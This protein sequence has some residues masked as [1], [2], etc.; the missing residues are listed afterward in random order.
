[1]KN[2]NFD[3]NLGKLP[4]QCLDLE[5]AVLGAIMIEKHFVKKILN[6]LPIE[7]FYVDRHQKI[8][9]AIG[10]LETQGSPVDIL[11]VTDKLRASGS[12]DLCGGPYY[13]TQL[14]SRVASAANSEMHA[15]IILQ[16]YI[17][18][19]IILHGTKAIADAYTDTEDVFDIKDGIAK[20]LQ[21]IDQL[22]SSKKKIDY[23]EAVN[24][25]IAN[26]EAL[27]DAEELVVGVETG[28]K[29][30]DKI[31]SGRCGG[32]LGIIA[33]RPSMGKTAYMLQEVINI[34][35]QG[36]PVGVISLETTCVKLLNRMLANMAMIDLDKIRRPGLLTKADRERI[37][38]VKPRLAGLPIKISDVPAM[39][40]REVHSQVGIWVFE[41]K[42][43]AVYVDYLQLMRGDKEKNGSR[44]QEVG[45]ISRG[46]KSIAKDYDIPVIALSQVGRA[47]EQRGGSKKPGLADLREAG[48]IE[49][50]ADTVQFLFRPEYYGIKEDEAGNSTAGK[51]EVYFGKNRDGV[52]GNF[53]VN[54]QGNFCRF[55]D[56]GHVDQYQSLVPP[57][58]KSKQTSFYD[59]P[60][61]DVPF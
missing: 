55:D 32:E 45:S 9:Q 40:Y 56:I 6:I 38:E 39:H 22:I 24:S 31:T 46:L 11:T 37:Q 18:R 7:A 33:A 12:L 47:T 15:Y 58:Q 50:D 2:E 44:Q 41:N 53:W 60:D 25:M 48:D 16:T 29:H 27:A 57:P 59:H 4:P 1:M 51:C 14:T 54:F 19:L 61:E 34:A 42:I 43:Q 52:T 21:T 20:A 36:I 26:I 13:I 8:F 28:F 17:K 23:P 10:Q 5:E 3:L 49:Q 35:S 30:Q